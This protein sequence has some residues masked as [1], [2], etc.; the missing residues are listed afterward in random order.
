MK[1]VPPEVRLHRLLGVFAVGHAVLL[2]FIFFPAVTDDWP[3]WMYRVWV[4]LATLW[5]LWPIVLAL[6]P[7]QSARRV[8]VPLAIAAPFVFFWFRVYS[9]LYAPSVFGLPEFV[10][11]T[12]RSMFQYAASF[13]HGWFDGRKTSKTGRLILEAYGPPLGVFTP[14]APKFSEETLKQCGIEIKFVASDVVSAPIIAHARGYNDAMMA[15]IRRRCPA[16]VKAAEDEDARWEQSYYDGEKAG[17]A[18]A[19]SDLR[20]GQLA[21][22]VSDP[23]K[24]SDAEF[25]KMLGEKYQ[26]RFKRLDPKA[27]PKMANKVYGQQ[28]GYNQIADAEIKRRFGK[29]TDY[30]IWEAWAKSR[31]DDRPR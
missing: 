7:A 10:R 5:F 21:I 15:E 4:G 2:F 13:G 24:K 23:P 6:H 25:E 18:E 20:A 8:L 17:R 28:S 16:V 22:V 30:A 27:D 9:S 12:P 11:L 29:A 31:F 26:L 14:G 1:S 3:Q 19:E